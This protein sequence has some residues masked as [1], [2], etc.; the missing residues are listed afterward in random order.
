V[1]ATAVW[2]RK[3]DRIFGKMKRRSGVLPGRV[4]PGPMGR[5][6]TRQDAFT[7]RGHRL[8]SLYRK[9]KVAR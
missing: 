1:K 8:G 3:G 7:F 2:L 6:T 4:F 5:C 9:A